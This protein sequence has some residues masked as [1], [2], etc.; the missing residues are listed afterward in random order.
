MGLALTEDRRRF[1]VATR[2]GRILV[3]D[4][5]TLEERTLSIENGS[6]PGWNSH[7]ASVVA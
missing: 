2:E 6:V 5:Q 4:A 3:L 7:L 1:V